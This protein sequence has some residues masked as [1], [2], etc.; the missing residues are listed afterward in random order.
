MAIVYQHIRKDTNEVFYVGIGKSIRRA[1]SK[2][3]RNTHW[4][5]LTNKNEY[6]VQ[7]THTGII[8]EE[9]C[10]IEK[11][12]IAFYGRNDLGLGPLVNMTDGGEGA[13]NPT[14]EIRQKQAN[15]KGKKHTPEAIEKIRNICL[16]MSEETKRKMSEA[17][18]GKPSHLKGKKWDE[19]FCKKAS[20]RQKGKPSNM[21]GRKFSE[22]SKKKLSDSL[23]NFY[24]RS[25]VSR[26]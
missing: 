23:I 15:R 25:N 18:K 3:N 20:L 17:K 26:G 16:N 1:Y 11:Y 4:L 10:S 21:K 9:A 22:E 6:S 14:E 2:A 12:L 24:K 5:N 19:E 7:I 13:V 8:W